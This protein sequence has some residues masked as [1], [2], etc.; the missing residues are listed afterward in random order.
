MGRLIRHWTKDFQLSIQCKYNFLSYSSHL[1]FWF[2]RY[3]P[4]TA[5]FN[6][7]DFL[8]RMPVPSGKV[9]CRFTALHNCFRD[10]A[11]LNALQV[12]LTNC[13][14]HRSRDFE[15]GIH[16]HLL[17]DSSEPTCTSSTVEAFLGDSFQC[18]ASERQLRSIALEERLVLLDQGIA[19]F[20]ED[21]DEVVN[22][23]WVEGRYDRQS[24]E[25][26][27]NQAVVLEICSNRL[28]YALRRWTSQRSPETDG[29]EVS[30]VTTF[31]LPLCP[32][33]AG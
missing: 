18:S 10:K 12:S 14:T 1:F 29:L 9:H 23:E 19:W 2:L 6:I 17:Q 7:N 26:L 16:E 27:G 20:C 30:R 3:R 15:H 28:E 22:R 33:D 21:P 24:T 11:E 5:I 13:Q 32:A 4:P 25:E 31:D 8:H